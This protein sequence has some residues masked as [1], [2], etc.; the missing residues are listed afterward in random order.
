[1]DRMV[2][3]RISQGRWLAI[4]ELARRESRSATVQLGLVIDCGMGGRAGYELSVM[5]DARSVRLMEAV[6]E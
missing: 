3:V 2:K 5:S 6:E 4:Q 1:M